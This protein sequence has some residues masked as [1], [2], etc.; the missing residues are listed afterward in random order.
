M[1]FPIRRV[2]TGHDAGGRSV[3]VSD[4][5][6]P[7]TSGTETANDFGRSELW[8]V[9]GPPITAHSGGER[10]AGPWQLEPPVGGASWRVM[11]LPATGEAAAPAADEIAKDPR[12]DADRPGMHTTD[13][14]DFIQILEGRVELSLD[15]GGVELSTGDC[16]VQRGTAHAWCVLGDEPCVF[17]AVM[18]RTAGDA[19]PSHRGVGPRSTTAPTGVGP[20]R[21]VTQ[22][23]E[24]GRSTF[25]SDGEPPNAV[26]LEHG[27]GMAY[28]DVWQTLG[29]V[30]SP[31]AGGDAAQGE[32]HLD[33]PG[34]GVAW[35][36]VVIPPASVLAGLDG[37][38]LAE[39]MAAR[40]PGMGEGGHHDP[41]QPGRHFT[42]SIDFVQI[43]EGTIRLTLDDDAAVDLSVGDCVVQ[44]GTWHTW[45]N[46]GDTPC[47]FQ[48]VMLTTQPL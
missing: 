32:M 25:A 43:L 26:L 10:E 42:D 33:P 5:T 23:D 39:E 3:F 7:D 19:D 12:F 4:G 29:P 15:E 1:T 36:R 28:I 21:V 37:R 47:V 41:D 38:K 22:I 14:I 46:L 40:A 20:R 48:A 24:G 45:T 44:R 9:P 11:R 34:G 13:T 8:H 2:V 30:T 6:P 16:V 31:A 27:G 35:K 18:L 17:S